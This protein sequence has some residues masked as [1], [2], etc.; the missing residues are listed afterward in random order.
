MKYKGAEIVGIPLV[1][2]CQSYGDLHPCDVP[3][4]P[5]QVFT[6]ETMLFF[7]GGASITFREEITKEEYEKNR[8]PKL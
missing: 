5:Y 7:K 4:E 1:F 2:E 8:L 6:K 3:Q